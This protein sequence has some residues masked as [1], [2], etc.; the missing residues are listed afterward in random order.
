MELSRIFFKG[1]EIWRAYKNNE[2]IWHQKTIKFF[3]AE[4]VEVFTFPFDLQIIVS[5]WQYY[6]Y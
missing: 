3:S 2:L 6:I 1:E 4:A 5:R